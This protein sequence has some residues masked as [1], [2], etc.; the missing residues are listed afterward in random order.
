MAQ[1]KAG[2]CVHWVMCFLFACVMP[3]ASAQTPSE[4][5]LGPNP[6]YTLVDYGA[7]FQVSGAYTR[8]YEGSCGPNSPQSNPFSLTLQPVPGDFVGA[9]VT[10]S[11]LTNGAPPTTDT[12]EIEGTPVTGSRVGVGTPGL[13]WSSFDAYAVSYMAVFPSALY[14]QAAGTVEIAGAT[15]KYLAGSVYGLA[16][17]LTVLAVYTNESE[18][19]RVVNLYRGYIS[20][21]S[22]GTCCVA[23]A[24]LNFSETYEAAGEIHFFINALDGQ[25]ESACSGS[26]DLFY[27][28]GANVGGVLAGTGSSTD[29]WQGLLGDNSLN[30]L[31]D[32]AEGDISAYV[33]VNDTSIGIQTVR[34]NTSEDCIGHSL[35]AISFEVE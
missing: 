4:T 3:C 27:V 26:R 24:T 22:S 19:L 18:P 21:Q 29:A 33:D 31:Y 12:I 10:W 5:G 17:G 14:P 20:T 16:E 35:A 6:F 9:L 32:H 8:V 30:N 28:N 11:Y 15:D 7:D 23:Q 34:Y 2:L 13:C 25:A 1:T